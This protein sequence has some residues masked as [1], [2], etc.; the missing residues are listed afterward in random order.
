MFS[1]FRSQKFVWGPP[2]GICRFNPKSKKN[3]QNTKSTNFLK[4][5]MFSTLKWKGAKNSYGGY[6]TD[7]APGAFKTIGLKLS[8]E[9]LTC[10][11]E[12]CRLKEKK[13][14][15]L[16]NLLTDGRR[17]GRTDGIFFSSTITFLSIKSSNS[18]RTSIQYF[19]FSVHEI[20]TLIAGM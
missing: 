6:P 13:L 11:G 7:F 20:N 17:R 2:Y 18:S 15:G 5:S 1:T 19:G 4:K 9:T 10:K 3:Y 12:V 14:C 16:Q 8:S